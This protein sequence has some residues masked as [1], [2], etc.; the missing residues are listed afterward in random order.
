MYA[1]ASVLVAKGQTL[2]QDFSYLQTPYLPLLYGGIFKMCGI[3]SFY[4]LTG[5]LISFLFL[6]ISLITVFLIARR[7]LASDIIISLSVVTLF[8]LNRS[9]VDPASEVSNYIMPLACSMLG[10]YIF[11]V[12]VED[13]IKPFRIALAGVIAAIAIGAKLTYASLVIPFIAIIVFHPLSE[14]SVAVNA[15]KRMTYVFFPFVAGLA[16]GLVPTIVFFMLDPKLFVFN[17]LGYHQVN[18]QWRQITGYEGPMSLYSKLAYAHQLFFKPDNLIII[19]GIM[20]G[21]GFSIN[22]IQRIRYAFKHISVGASLVLLL[23]LIAIPTA[24]AP[25]PS[26]PQY[27]AMPVSF[28]LL[29]LIYAIASNSLERPTLYRKLLLIQV[30]LTLACNGPFLLTSMSRLT[31]RDGWSGVYVHDVSMSIKNIV[32]DRTTVVNHRIATLSPLFV[33]EA[34]L[35]IYSE[36]STGPF[37]YR[38]GDLLN[39]EDRNHYVGTSPKSIADLFGKEAPVAVLVGFERELDRPLVEYA[40]NNSYVEVHVP[41]FGGKLY[42]RP[43]NPPKRRA[44][45]V[46]VDGATCISALQ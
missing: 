8:L 38:V 31:Y 24:L 42:I 7:V 41:E 9:I 39:P 3:T 37:L 33:I 18:A 16:I 5:K 12:S 10:F 29:L 44:E 19:L 4:L 26:F 2:Y 30:L 11:V 21:L 35:P 34:N 13:K 28:L 40:V 20:L 45:G 36:L 25:T 6:C 1:A 14:H 43:E 23:V 15:K 32:A 17:N 46:L 22:R 27:F